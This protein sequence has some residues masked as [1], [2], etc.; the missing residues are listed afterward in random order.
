VLFCVSLN[1]RWVTYVP[2]VVSFRYAK[3]ASAPERSDAEEDPEFVVRE[4]PKYKLQL[5]RRR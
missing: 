3:N 2:Q 1:E 5:L 4:A